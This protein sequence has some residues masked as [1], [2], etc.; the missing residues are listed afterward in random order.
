MREYATVSPVFWTGQTGRRLKQAG[1]DAMLV[2]MYLVTS[3]HSNA[4]GMFYL[5]TLYIS[6]E[7][8]LTLEGA[9]KALA[10]ACEE[11]FC[12]YDDEAEVV[13]VFEMARFQIGQ[14]LSPKDNRV[15][16][17]NE[18]YVK[19]PKCR[20]LKDFF[21]KYA[22]AF[23]LKESRDGSPS[24]V[25]SEPHRSQEQEQEQEQEK[26][27]ATYGRLS[28][29]EPADGIADG[30]VAGGSK[31][32]EAKA[33]FVSVRASVPLSCPHEEI[34]KAYHEI[35]PELPR[36]QVWNKARRK[37]LEARWREDACRQNLDWWRGYFQHARKCPLLFGSNDRGW[38][39]DLEWLIL[40]S[41]M[42]KVIEGRYVPAAR[43][44]PGQAQPRTYQ[45]YQREER[46]G[47]AIELMQAMGMTGGR[48]AGVDEARRVGG[49]AVFQPAASELLPKVAGGT[50]RLERRDP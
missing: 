20:F 19:L 35:L 50:G 48:N 16:W 12:A 25:P 17:V 49:D 38:K 13:W 41:N 28:A 2:A 9:S 45:E 22:T 43:A 47:T 4:M 6:H 40:P 39:A 5:P 31:A 3:P 29:A 30:D 42:P 26:D 23:H 11:G 33:E 1:P 15:K 24:E 46:R 27:I 8:G 32:V 36:V 10:R 14:A 18:E 44:S 37:H 7:T 21:N 34:V